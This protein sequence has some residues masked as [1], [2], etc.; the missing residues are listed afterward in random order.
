MG[1][2]TIVEPQDFVLASLQGYQL[3]SPTSLLRMMIQQSNC[4]LVVDR[5]L[6]MQN[7]MQ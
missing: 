6:A 7:M 4:F 5:G 3:Q 1:V 2:A